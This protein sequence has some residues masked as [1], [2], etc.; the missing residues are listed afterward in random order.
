MIQS[1]N[2]FLFYPSKK[3]SIQSIHSSSQSA[4]SQFIFHQH[5]WLIEAFSPHPLFSSSSFFNSRRFQSN[6]SSI[7]HL[8][9][10]TPVL[11]HPS[12]PLIPITIRFFPS[13]PLLLPSRQ[14]RNW[15][16]VGLVGVHPSQSNPEY[17]PATI[18]SIQSNPIHSS[19]HRHS[20]LLSNLLLCWAHLQHFP[21]QFSPY[22]M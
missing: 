2:P 1:D 7:L 13:F 21:H 16:L 14:Q 8:L 12:N 22:N 19:I 15:Q 9:P 6:H 17:S 5:S 18:K 11:I 3:S 20:L 10:P 4:Q